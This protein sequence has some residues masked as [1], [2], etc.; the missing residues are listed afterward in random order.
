LQSLFLE[1][2]PLYNSFLSLRTSRPN[3]TILSEHLLDFFSFPNRRR[4]G[5][6][7]R[8]GYRPRLVMFASMA[9]DKRIGPFQSFFSTRALCRWCL[10]A[11][12]DMP[13]ILSFFSPQAVFPAPPG[14]RP[15]CVLIDV[16]LVPST[17]LHGTLPH[18]SSPM[19]DFIVL[20]SFG[21][22]SSYY[23][24][25]LPIGSSPA[26]S[27]FPAESHGAY[28]FGILLCDETISISNQEILRYDFDAQRLALTDP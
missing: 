17:F 13:P 20:R 8:F 21:R 27:R 23:G 5:D 6:W 24:D 4:Q 19:S 1:S 16:W 26:S 9:S 14:C 10:Q 15:W 22:S 7:F 11:F 3:Q 28:P 12:R 2:S 18:V 25:F